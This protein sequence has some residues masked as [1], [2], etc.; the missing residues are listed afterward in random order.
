MLFNMLPK[1]VRLLSLNRFKNI[2]KSILENA[3]LYKV[4]DFEE[5]VDSIKTQVKQT[6]FYT[7][8]SLHVLYV[9]QYLRIEL[10]RKNTTY[11]LPTLLALC[12]PTCDLLRF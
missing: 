9:P 7:C 12:P 5:H 1:E 3:C 10:T 8:V 2:M 4:D 11:L 6:K